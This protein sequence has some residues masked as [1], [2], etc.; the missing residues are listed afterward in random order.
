VGGFKASGPSGVDGGVV[1]GR[2][3]SITASGGGGGS[4]SGQHG[5]LTAVSGWLEL[6]WAGA[7]VVGIVLVGL[8]LGVGSG[9]GWLDVGVVGKQVVGRKVDEPAGLAGS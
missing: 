2:G 8:W 9:V 6:R 1:I 4:G 5:V 7:A 3:S